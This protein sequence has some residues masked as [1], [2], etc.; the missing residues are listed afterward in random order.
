MRLSRHGR[1]RQRRT[2]CAVVTLLLAAAACR[3]PALGRV[4]PASGTPRGAAEVA[5]VGG[6]PYALETYVWRDY[7]PVAPPSGLLAV[8]RVVARDSSAVPASFHVDSVWITHRDRGDVWATVPTD[9]RP[10]LPGWPY[11]EVVARNGPSWEPGGRV[12]VVVRLRTA[13]GR[14]VLLLVRDQLINQ[15][16]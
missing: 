3:H 11:Y 1:W 16:S 9:D 10:A 15:T 8:V 13:P 4:E 5:T 7:M 14:A 2:E 12:D 6:V